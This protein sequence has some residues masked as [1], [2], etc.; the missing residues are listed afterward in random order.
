MACLL[1]CLSGPLVPSPSAPASPLRPPPGHTDFEQRQLLMVFTCSKCNTRAA[2][3][4]SKQAYEQ[5]RRAGVG[6]G[7][8]F[9][10]MHAMRRSG[11]QGRIAALVRLHGTARWALARQHR[12][13]LLLHGLR[14]PPSAAL[15]AVRCISAGCCWA[16]CCRAW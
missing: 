5:V 12:R 15:T 14:L 3:A 13:T 10:S 9:G 11:W 16:L 7:Q 1:A 8:W 6:G 4:F 2:K